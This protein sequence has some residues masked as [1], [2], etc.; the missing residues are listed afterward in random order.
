MSAWWA[1]LGPAQATVQCR[2]DRHRLRWEAGTLRALDH[3]DPDDERALAA[4]GGESVPCLAL[5]DAWRRRRDDV[6]ALVLGSRGAGD[7]PHLDPATLP[8]LAPGTRTGAAAPRTRGAWFTY[9]TGGT[10]IPAS[11]TPRGRAENELVWLLCLG[12][13]IGDR[14]IATVAATWAR[15][16]HEGYAGVADTRPALHAALHARVAATLAQWLGETGEHA[17]PEVTLIDAGDP[18]SVIRGD[19]GR[20]RAALPFDWIAEVHAKGLAVVAG[21]FCLAAEPVTDG[22][23]HRDG[24][25]WRLITIGPDLSEPEPAEL[26]FGGPCQPR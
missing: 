15:R 11:N 23:G 25:G 21:R 10:P 16:L 12:G 24:H 9:R 19:D 26:T 22:D 14:L 5:L 4:L 20:V 3:G 18:R 17:E 7:R 1:G 2:R 13:G 8:P 6:R